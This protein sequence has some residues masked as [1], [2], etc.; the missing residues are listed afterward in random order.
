VALFRKR[1][2]SKL[3]DRIGTA[4]QSETRPI[5]SSNV[6]DYFC[7]VL[8]SAVSAAGGAVSEFVD[9][10]RTEPQRP[11]L[12]QFLERLDHGAD[13]GPPVRLVAWGYVNQI[14]DETWPDRRDE[15][16]AVAKSGL[17]VRSEWEERVAHLDPRV[18]TKDN[19]GMMLRI[20][21]TIYEGMIASVNGSGGNAGVDL[22]AIMTWSQV[23][24]DN[25]G[26]YRASL[27][28]LTRSGQPE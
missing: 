14:V 5:G 4:V 20:N 24:S 7:C 22:P 27:E 6:D 19:A 23:F 15:V 9:A 3:D 2:Q 8:M 25:W 1:R 13:M 28:H 10:I 26:L 18:G 17:G 11:E 12:E 21:R 16:L